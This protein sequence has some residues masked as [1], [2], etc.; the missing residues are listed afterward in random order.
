VTKPKDF[1]VV[2]PKMSENRGRL[3]WA[4]LANVLAARHAF[5]I[6]KSNQW[7]AANEKSIPPDRLSAG[8]ERRTRSFK[9]L[10]PDLK[11]GETI[12]IVILG[13]CGEG[14][15]SQYGL[16]PLIRALKPDFM[17]INGDV[18]YP[19]G[20][21]RDF[22]EGFFQPFNDL[23]IPIWAVPG[24]HEYYSPYK[25]REFVD[26]FCTRKQVRNW[27]LYGLRFVPQPGTYWELRDPEVSNVSII[28]IDSGHSGNLDSDEAGS[29]GQIDWLRKRLSAAD[30]EGLSVILLFH[31]PKLADGQIVKEPRLG[32]LHELIAGSSAVKV[33]ICAHVHNFQLYES[34]DF[35]K[36][37]ELIAR[38]TIDHEP[39]AYFVSGCGGAYLSVPPKPGEMK[40]KVRRVFPTFDEWQKQAV[41]SIPGRL[42]NL[43]RRS[44]LSLV[45]PVD[46]VL[47]EIEEGQL[48]DSDKP[49]LLSLLY[50]E[51]RK[52]KTT[53]TPV[54]LKDLSA[55]YPPNVHLVSIQNNSPEPDQNLVDHCKQTTLTI[56]IQKG[57]GP[58]PA[59]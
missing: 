12:R 22:V 28:G 1:K 52:D 26:V 3:F 10:V 47:A 20:R 45:R 13:D 25:G 5:R 35:R 7:R 39:P 46:R 18:A 15:K 43:A 59:P 50:L 36:A 53:I 40:Y 24:N 21:T 41:T 56:Q 57:P 16:V 19:A 2:Y 37:L 51:I 6:D 8:E 11:A 34:P 54:F 29:K 14:D 30:E 32:R 27:S 9:T 38:Q 49:G 31:I 4:R 44:P 55:L 42:V 33:V 58:T 17:I 48:E 23:G